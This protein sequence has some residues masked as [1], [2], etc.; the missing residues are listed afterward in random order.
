MRLKL[1]WLL[2]LHSAMCEV[3][4]DM[5]SLRRFLDGLLT[6]MMRETVDVGGDSV[7]ANKVGRLESPKDATLVCLLLTLRVYRCLRGGPR[8]QLTY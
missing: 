7:L 1:E 4:Y 5:C 6:V 2:K 3:D 8:Y